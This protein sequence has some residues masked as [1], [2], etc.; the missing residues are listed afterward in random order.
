MVYC[1]YC[2]NEM[3][4]IGDL[5]HDRKEKCTNRRC[6]SNNHEG[7]TTPTEKYYAMKANKG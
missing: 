1:I 7:Y 3:V 5:K 2:G 4:I 6:Y